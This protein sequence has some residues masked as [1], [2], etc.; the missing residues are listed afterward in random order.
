MPP[1]PDLRLR[2]VVVR[3]GEPGAI[4]NPSPR[5]FS[6]SGG[7][8]YVHLSDPRPLP[9]ARHYFF[10]CARTDPNVYELSDRARRTGGSVTFIVRHV[11]HELARHVELTKASLI[12]AFGCSNQIT[13]ATLREA[14]RRVLDGRRVV[15]TGFIDN[16]IGVAPQGGASAGTFVRLLMEASRLANGSTDVVAAALSLHRAGSTFLRDLIGLTVSG[17]VHVLHENAVPPQSECQP[18][19]RRAW[20]RKTML[21]ARRRFIFV[22]ERPPDDRLMSSFQ[23]RHCASLQSS[24]DRTHRV[25]RHA[26]GIQRTFNEWLKTQVPVLEQWYP[27]QLVEAFGVDI[28]AADRTADGFLLGHHA[29]NTLLVVPTARLHALRAD[30]ASTFGGQDAFWT[31]ATNSATATR[32]G[33][34]V[35]TAFRRQIRF[36]AEMTDALWQIP[37]VAHLHTHPSRRDC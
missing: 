22:A 35:D 21:G 20:L 7:V 8:A 26:A 18:D 9:P 36:P 29:D 25:L 15:A 16:S 31:I 11:D 17:R 4:R 33:A 28:L 1:A 6:G 5:T 37:E 24:Y 34:E 19:E 13:D 2:V 23:R 27:Q 32:S 3:D 12:P 30:V 10:N 14:T